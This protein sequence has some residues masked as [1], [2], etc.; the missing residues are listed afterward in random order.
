M[1]IFK[2]IYTNKNIIAHYIQFLDPVLSTPFIIECNF[3]PIAEAMIVVFVKYLIMSTVLRAQVLRACN[4][5]AHFKSSL[6]CYLIRTR[7]IAHL[8]TR[9]GS[10]LILINIIARFVVYKS[11]V[12]SLL[13]V[14]KLK[15]FFVLMLSLLPLL[16]LYSHKMNNTYGNFEMSIITSASI[17]NFLGL[18]LNCYVVW[19]M[20][21][22][23]RETLASDFFSLN[24]AVSEILFS[25][26]TIWLYMYLQ[27]RTW[28]CFEAFVFSLG[29]FFTARPLFQCCIC[30]EYYAGV[31]HP[32]LFLRFKHMRYKVACCCVAWSFALV[33]C[34][35]SWRTFS[36]PLYLYGFLIQNALFFFVILFSCLSVL[37]AL[38]HPG[39]GEKATDKKKCNAAKRRAFKIIFLITV[40]MAINFF[41]YVAYIP[42]QCCLKSHEFTN[43][44][45]ICIS[46]ALITG[47][48]QPLLYLNRTRKLLCF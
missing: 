32:V 17:N 25:L 26:S 35:Y 15:L 9:F 10:V 36:N 1:L 16:L 48:V 13:C 31:V 3:H 34:F 5:R 21:A 47:W 33:S 30:V 2:C 28:F 14:N 6:H 8:Y 38:K 19:L 41:L 12:H 11:I 40:Y 29:L 7:H 39:P 42:L 4:A 20:L 46:L 22:G 23:T 37:R 18:P 44:F 27:L 45:T 24:L 43:G